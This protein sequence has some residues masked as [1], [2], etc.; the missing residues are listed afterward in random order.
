ML[1]AHT[2]TSSEGSQSK[3]QQKATRTPHTHRYRRNSPP[4]QSSSLLWSSTLARSPMQQ[5]TRN[6]PY[7]L[8]C[9]ARSK[10]SKRRI[11]YFATD[12]WA[13]KATTPTRIISKWNRRDIYIN[14]IH[15]VPLCPPP[16]P[17]LS[18]FKLSTFKLPT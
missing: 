13:M 12:G 15:I 10:V 7:L 11:T 8:V 16:A 2:Q 1:L 3:K 6:N 14:S 9:D 5:S 17:R 18:A 4:M